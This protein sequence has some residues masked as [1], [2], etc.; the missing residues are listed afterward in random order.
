MSSEITTNVMNGIN[1]TAPVEAQAP[2]ETL[3]EIETPKDEDHKFGKR[4]A[5]I[6]AKERALKRQQANMKAEAAAVKEFHEN[7]KQA[8]T[9]PL[10]YLGSLGLNYQQLTEHVLNDSK[11]TPEMQIKALEERL[12]ADRAERLKEQQA[13]Q[14]KQTQAIIEN[15]KKQIEQV[16]NS[17]SDEFE[18]IQANQAYDTVLDVIEAYWKQTGQII[19]IDIAAKH[20]EEELESQARKLLSLK[21][22]AVKSAPEVSESPKEAPKLFNTPRTLTNA[23]VA[24]ANPQVN[25]PLLSRD[26]SIK[27]LG[28]LLRGG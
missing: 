21:K 5:A 13:S 14:S 16:V 7:K 1:A 18:L 26:E 22:F 2:V 20:V 19:Q 8:K 6:A 28:K 12:E 3:R 17:K 24:A 15:H 23:A 27:R 11:P 9:N 25:E 10:A 4:F